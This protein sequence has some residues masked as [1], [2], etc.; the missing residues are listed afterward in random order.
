VKVGDTDDEEAEEETELE[1]YKTV[2]ESYETPVDEDDLHYI[3]T[4]LGRCAPSLMSS[5]FLLVSR[6]NRGEPKVIF[7]VAGVSSPHIDTAYRCTSLRRK[8]MQRRG[9]IELW[10]R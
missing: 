6:I 7:G 3:V 4:E 1:S 2:L 5:D 9:C 8:P 10:V